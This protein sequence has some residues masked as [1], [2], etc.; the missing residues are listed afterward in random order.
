MLIAKSCVGTDAIYALT[1]N[2]VPPGNPMLQCLANFVVVHVNAF[3]GMPLVSSLEQAARRHGADVVSRPA[4]VG[5][6]FIMRTPLG[7]V[8]GNW[9][10]VLPVFL[11]LLVGVQC[12]PDVDLSTGRS[13]ASAA[14]PGE[15]HLSARVAE[16][17]IERPRTATGE[18]SSTH[19]VPWWRRVIP[20]LRPRRIL[21]PP[22]PDPGLNPLLES[23]PLAQD[24]VRRI[25]E[26]DERYRLDPIWLPGLET[27]DVRP[28]GARTFRAWAWMVYDHDA[29]RVLLA[30]H[31]DRAYPVASITKL[32]S[33]LV[34]ADTNPDLDEVLTILWEDKYFVLPTRSK[35][36]IG[37]KYRAGDLWYQALLS[38]DNRAMVA[39]MRQ[40]H[41]PLAVFVEAMN[42][43]AKAIGLTRGAFV[44]PTGLDPRNVCSARDTIV[45]L[46][47]AL[48]NPFLRRILTTPEHRYRRL[49]RD[50]SILA[51]AT[52]RLMFRRHWDV[53]ASKTGYTVMSGSCLVTRCVIEDGRN[54]SIAILGGRGLNGRYPVA[55]AMRERLKRL[56]LEP[57]A[58]R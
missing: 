27:G 14:L 28:R 49:D 29:G 26:A 40:S 43:R 21:P 34:L 56:S 12:T 53:V 2:S 57:V 37:G 48:R 10:R 31:A 1:T 42:R 17:G 6:T 7:R 54:V 25:A 22:E 55:E 24:A 4:P 5:T 33:A 18:T 8:G 39:L 9:L 58:K 15:S 51:R 13:S 11:F 46:E 52:N 32:L 16:S 44:E 3:S 20:G 19:E 47:A 30:H 35:L 38:S 41:L 23:D 50:V 45:L 36:R